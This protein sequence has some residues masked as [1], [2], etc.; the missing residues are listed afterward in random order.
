MILVAGFGFF[1]M[2]NRMGIIN[3][4]LL[5]L[6]SCNVAV[7]VSKGMFY[8][9]VVEN[10]AAEMSITGQETRIQLRYRFPEHKDFEKFVSDCSLYKEKSK[11]F[12]SKEVEITNKI[13]ADK[14]EDE[15][16]DAEFEAT[17]AALLEEDDDKKVI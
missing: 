10:A 8:S 16:L 1:I 2:Y 11:E 6:V 7:F 17:L 12:K 13:K 5:A 4:L 15:A 3:R 14:A 9:S